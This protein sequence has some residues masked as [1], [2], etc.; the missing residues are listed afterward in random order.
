MQM[1]NIISTIKDADKKITYQVIAYRSLTREELI[2]S[3]RQFWAQRNR[4]KVKP[5]S[6]IKII[7]TIGFRN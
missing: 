6:T 1:P 7:S 4:P 3:V 2:L 5:G